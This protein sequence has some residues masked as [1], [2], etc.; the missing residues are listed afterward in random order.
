M[1][2][3]RFPD[4][5]TFLPTYDC[6][7]ACDNCCFGSHP[8]IAERLAPDRM[9]RHIDQVAALGSVRL[10]VFSGGEC[11]KLGEDLVTAV[12]RCTAHGLATRCVTNAYWARTEEAAVSR[13]RPLKDAG[14]GELNVSTGDEHQAFVPVGNVVNAVRAADAVGMS[15][16]VVVE[17][18]Q[19]RSFTAA[20][21]RAEPRWAELADRH[22]APVVFE[23]PWMSM[24]AER[25]VPQSAA[26]NAT[27]A[28]LHRR[29]GCD[30][31]LR[32]VVV[33][34][35]ERLGAC[36]GLTR[37]QIPELTV[38]SLRTEAMADLVDTMFDDLVKIWIAVDGPDHIL[39]WA[40]THDP[41]I[42]WEGR[43][44]HHCDSCRFM[45]GDPAVRKVIVEHWEEVADDVLYRF[46]AITAGPVSATVRSRNV[47]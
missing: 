9:L 22:A 32:T 24:D 29:A 5:V 2:F 17:A 26:K 39:A 46:A 44:A 19:E 21:L 43:F 30:S 40:A 23:S 6:T 25:P 11:F 1:T 15:A 36:C 34:P 18:Q 37:E 12:A 10:V 27:R 7:A 28:N 13:L 35:D 33:T 14:L 20:A 16:L 8:G 45:Y 31:V 41:S 42:A 3:R 47:R 38:G 4:T